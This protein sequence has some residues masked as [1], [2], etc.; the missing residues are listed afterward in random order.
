VT[1]PVPDLFDPA[2]A[3]DVYIERG[4]AAAAWGARLR[5][6][7]GVG[8]ASADAARIA[9]FGIDCQIGF[10]S[11]GA[12]LFVPGAVEDTARA[13]SWI[14]RHL[15]R[16]TGLIFSLDTHAVHQIFH[17]A[18]WA[19]AA[20]AHPPPLTAITAA[21]VE[22]GRWRALQHASAS[23]EYCRRLEATGKY[24]LTVWPFH[25]LLG[26]TSHAL[27]PA[28][29]EASIVHAVARSAPTRFVTKGSHPQTE[30]YSV[31]SPEVEQI[32]GERVGAFDEA[33][34]QALMSFDR[35]Y[36]FGQASSHCV[37]ATLRDLAD[38]VEA[39]CPDR[40]GSIYVLVD[41]MSPVPAP[42]LDPL[43]PG[44]DFPR[45]AAEG[46]DALAAR[47]VRLVKTTDPLS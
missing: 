33:L 4:G 36:V 20:G 14:Y 15:D 40:M 32:G 41:A 21:D 19:D 34:F 9:A 30:N 43:P 13:V 17:P 6:G 27:A 2:R 35:V 22:A 8:P 11:P 42:P 44:L 31:L 24:V 3:G 1:L 23:L 29:M 28:V 12:S 39:T 38:R 25:T 26:G 16:I 45:L 37:L 46:L 18:W 10:C 47:G 7:H 5:D